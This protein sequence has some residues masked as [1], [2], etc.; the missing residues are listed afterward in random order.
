MPLLKLDDADVQQWGGG[1]PL[2]LLPD[3]ASVHFADVHV[4]LGSAFKVVQVKAVYNCPCTL[5]LIAEEMQRSP[6]PLMREDRG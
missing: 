5:A 1:A 6:P 2:L 4:A 3:C